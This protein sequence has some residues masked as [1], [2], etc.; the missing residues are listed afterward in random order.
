V[1]YVDCSTSIL[2]LRKTQ[3]QTCL[4]YT[5]CRNT[6]Q[7]EGELLQTSHFENRELNI[8]NDVNTLFAYFSVV[9]LDDF[10]DLWNDHLYRFVKD[11]Y[12]T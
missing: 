4:L 6:Y 11:S 3:F 1:F 12:N 9:E 7:Q 10:V 8:T 2:S 5:H